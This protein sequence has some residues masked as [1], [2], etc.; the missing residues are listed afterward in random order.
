MQKKEKSR[1]I[2]EWT[3][4]NSSLESYDIF[5]VHEPIS[6]LWL[7]CVSGLTESGIESHFIRFILV[8]LG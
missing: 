5:F 4:L 3:N 7:D 8:V 6:P 2:R 1:H